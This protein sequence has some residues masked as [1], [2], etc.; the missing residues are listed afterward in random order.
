MDFVSE[1]C[2]DYEWNEYEERDLNQM[3]FQNKIKKK[4]HNID[5]YNN[6]VW[7]DRWWKEHLLMREKEWEYTW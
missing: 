6:L 5:H 2:W 1:I 4:K 3:L 7:T